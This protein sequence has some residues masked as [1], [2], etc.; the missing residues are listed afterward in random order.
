VNTWKTAA[1]I[2]PRFLLLA[3]PAGASRWDR[4]A[5]SVIELPHQP[6]ALHNAS[7]LRAR[8]IDLLKIE[9]RPVKGRPWDTAFISIWRVLSTNIEVT[10]AQTNLASVAWRLEFWGLPVGGL[11]RWLDQRDS[12][13]RTRQS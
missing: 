6:G 1:R 9:G 12:E 7:I 2:T 5:L 10:A 13:A 4:Q 3:P 11:Y 8:G